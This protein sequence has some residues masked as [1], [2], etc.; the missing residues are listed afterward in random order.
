M[1]RPKIDKMVGK[2]PVFKEFKPVG[3]PKKNIPEVKMSLEEYEA[4]RL[5]DYEAFTQEQAAEEMEI[6]RPTF[7]R[8]IE[9][10][11]KKLTDFLIHG[12]NLIIDGGAVH[13]RENVFKC[14]D[15]GIHFSADFTEVVTECPECGSGNLDNLAGGFGHGR[16]CVNRKG[17]NND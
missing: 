14:N 16:C 12:K 11:R 6:S 15:C 8:L 7:T 13:F 3:I 5:A 4:L 9:E 17:K 1:P 2:P 10:A